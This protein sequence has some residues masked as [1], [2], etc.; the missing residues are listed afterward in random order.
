MSDYQQYVQERDKIDFF[1]QKGYRIVKVIEDLNGALISFEKTNK[2]NKNEV[3][4]S[5]RVS[6]AHGRKYFAVKL[7]QQTKQK[8]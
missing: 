3:S 1:I 4:E 5:L 2:L 6:T 8:L 7:I